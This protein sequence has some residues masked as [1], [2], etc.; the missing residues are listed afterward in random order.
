MANEPDY[1]ELFYRSQ[2]KLVTAIQTLDSVSE[3]LKHFMQC[4]EEE[5]IGIDDEETNPTEA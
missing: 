5:V 4:C 3:M 2:A 1:K